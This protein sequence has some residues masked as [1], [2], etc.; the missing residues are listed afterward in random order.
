[1]DA[2]NVKILEENLRKNRKILWKL[3]IKPKHQIWVKRP[4]KT[5]LPWKH[6]VT[7]SKNW[8]TKVSAG[9]FSPPPPPGRI[10][11][12]NV[13][14]FLSCVQEDAY[15]RIRG[16]SIRADV[17]QWRFSS[18]GP[19]NHDYLPDRFLPGVGLEGT[20]NSPNCMLQ[21]CFHGYNAAV[22]RGDVIQ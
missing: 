6:E 16:R 10:I 3:K 18:R 2:T 7:W 11:R 5:W 19:L 17:E 22:S 8:H 12:V 15:I 1:M 9:T 13:I 20:K 4:V 14:I 21:I